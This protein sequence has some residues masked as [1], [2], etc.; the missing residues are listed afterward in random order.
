M[1][2]MPME[3]NDAQKELQEKLVLYQLLQQTLESLKGQ[4]LL[5]QNRFVELETT[6]QALEDI[7]GLNA[8]NETL[9]PLGSGFY[10][11]GKINDTKKLLVNVGAGV[12]LNK[13]IGP[14]M[15]MINEKRAEVEKALES[16]QEN[17]NHIVQRINQIGA[18][19]QEVISSQRGK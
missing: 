7:K 5:L 15:D 9:V 14:S 16:I 3:S 2:K 18:E 1:E 13:E 12:M 10:V 4:A 19:L 6:K 11:H 17:L 8:A